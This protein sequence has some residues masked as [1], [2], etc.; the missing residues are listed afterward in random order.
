MGG[1]A[2]CLATNDLD[3]AA[4]YRRVA[5]FTLMLVVGNIVLLV[6]TLGLHALSKSER[7]NDESSDGGDSVS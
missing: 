3:G 7:T 2:L 1:Y 6:G 5:M 4:M